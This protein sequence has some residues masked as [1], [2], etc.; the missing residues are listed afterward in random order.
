MQLHAQA[1]H[2]IKSA[3]SS[4]I[5][6]RRVHEAPLLAEG[7]LAIDGCWKSENQFLHK[8]IPVTTHV[9]VE[10]SYTCPHRGSSK[11]T[12]CVCKQSMWSWEGKV[13]EGV[14]G[15][16]W[17]RLGHSFDWNSL[18]VCM[19]FSNSNLKKTIV[20]CCFSLPGSCILP[21]QRVGKD[22]RHQYHS[23]CFWEMS[24]HT[25]SDLFLIFWLDI[26]V[27]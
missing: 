27:N 26:I 10:G 5:E 18:N 11:E 8:A 22:Q 17:R 13:V 7:L 24:L 25:D 6:E 2:V 4:Y 20:F 21:T 3:P 9:L 15:E 1:L 23:K 16:E 19:K 14:V 12:Q